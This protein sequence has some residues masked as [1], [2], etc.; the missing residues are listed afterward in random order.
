MISLTIHS[1]QFIEISEIQQLNTCSHTQTITVTNKDGQQV[2]IVL[3]AD[4]GESANLLES[5]NNER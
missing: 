3:F 4:P 5:T 2:E 1:V